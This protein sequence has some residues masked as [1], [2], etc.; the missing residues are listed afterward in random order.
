MDVSTQTSPKL[1][2]PLVMPDQAQK[3]VTV[4]E[5]LLRLD[6]L[7][8][9]TVRSRSVSSQP[10]APDDGDVWILP[11]PAT[12]EA[13]VHLPEG[14]L[15]VWR[16]GLWSSITPEEGWRAWCRDEALMI[17]FTNGH[18]RAAASDRILAQG[19]AG[20]SVRAIVIEHIETGLSGTE[21]VTAAVIP[22]RSV[23]FCV[24]V[25]TLNSI[26]GAQSFDCG[27]AG[28]RSK[29]GGSLGCAA[30]ASNLGVIGP[31]AFYADTP[32]RLHANGGAFAGG[33]VGLAI[34]AWTAEAIPPD[35]S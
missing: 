33:R 25:R 34:H 14:S 6:A 5:S 13:W 7:V 29:F 16:D 19:E 10:A 35:V 3:H 12:G 15:A 31:T 27:I 28:E 2:L 8:Q 9:L 11:G 17:H 21:V 1:D 18:W 26:S 32:V 23:V 22:A 20:A 30:G 4:N 24:S